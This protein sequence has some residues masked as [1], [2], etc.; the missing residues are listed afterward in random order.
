MLTNFPRDKK[1]NF[2]NPNE[3]KI[4]MSIWVFQIF[5][6]SIWSVKMVKSEA[7]VQNDF[8]L[9]DNNVSDVEFPSIFDP[10]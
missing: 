3:E 4:L 2:Y 7:K 6:A 9:Y 8:I 10:L 1:A 5:V